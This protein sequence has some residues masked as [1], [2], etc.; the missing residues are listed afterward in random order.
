MGNKIII[1]SEA[2]IKRHGSGPVR[3]LSKSVPSEPIKTPTAGW[4]IHE[5][6]PVSMFTLKMAKSKEEKLKDT[7]RE[8]KDIIRDGSE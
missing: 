2:E 4:M 7:I 3:K 1:P 6:A 5:I 8:I